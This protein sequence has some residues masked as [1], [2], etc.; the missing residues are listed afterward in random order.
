MGIGKFIAGAAGLA[1][2]AGIFSLPQVA[3]LAGDVL[4]GGAI[5][6]AQ[7][8]KDA[9]TQN[10]GLAREQMAFQE[11]MS[12]SAY[13]RAMDDMGKAGLNPMLAFSQGG[14]ST[15]AGAMGH[16]DPVNQGSG[17]MIARGLRQV[18]EWDQFK[19]QQDNTKSSTRLND[20]NA[21][22][23]AKTVDEKVTAADKNESQT[24]LNNAAN[25]KTFADTQNSM[26][27]NKILRERARAAAAEAD[28]AE[29]ERDQQ[30]ARQPIDRN[31]APVDAVTERAMDA[32][33]AITT[34][35]GA[36]RSS[37]RRRSTRQSDINPGTGEITRERQYD[38]EEDR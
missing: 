17:K 9:N 3:G 1:S 23:A 26:Q 10:V 35:R 25:S 27:T 22:V 36:F 15:P 16:V 11:R 20:Q 4:T 19:N 31:M 38:I 33:G 18:Q 28:Q 32:L 29:F 5:S 30:K 24:R 34:G 37:R 14:A 6:D 21:D 13:Q 2:P 12:N 8:V 7:A